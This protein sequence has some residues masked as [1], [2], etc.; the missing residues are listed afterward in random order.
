MEKNLKNSDSFPVFKQSLAN[1]ALCNVMFLET[2]NSEIWLNISSRSPSQ[3]LNS[4]LQS[5]YLVLRHRCF[6]TLSSL[7]FPPTVFF[8]SASWKL[9]YPTYYF[10]FS[11][12][13]THNLAGLHLHYWLKEHNLYHTLLRSPP[14]HACSLIAFK[15]QKRK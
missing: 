2:W 15:L 7:L 11:Q 8:L 10:Q 12:P 13:T 1:I 14:P 4:A 9:L 5:Y 3:P 6:S